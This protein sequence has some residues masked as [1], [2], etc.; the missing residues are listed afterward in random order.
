MRFFGP[1][2]PLGQNALVYYT[3]IKR[4]VKFVLHRWRLLRHSLFF[5]NPL[6]FKMLHFY[7]L[8]MERIN[9]LRHIC[10]S[11]LHISFIIVS[12][13]ELWLSWHDFVSLLPLQVLAFIADPC[14]TVHWIRSLKEYRTNRNYRWCMVICNCLIRD[15]IPEKWDYN[16]TL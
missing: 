11:I 1:S 5:K 14:F 12:L 4:D 2:L 16:F 7:F 6:T 15:M 9:F 3:S 13:R 8:W 10:L